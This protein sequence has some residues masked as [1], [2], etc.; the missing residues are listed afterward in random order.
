MTKAM[1]DIKSCSTSFKTENGKESY[2]GR[3]VE[4]VWGNSNFC[5]KTVNGKESYAG[6]DDCDISYDD[7]LFQHRKR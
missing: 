3:P 1:W 4:N 7:D 6:G 5:F 2:A